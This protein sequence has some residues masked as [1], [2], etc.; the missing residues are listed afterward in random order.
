M[1]YLTRLQTTKIEMKKG[2]NFESA[3]KNLKPPLFWKDKD[4]FKKHCVNWP[5]ESIEKSLNK[6]SETEILCKLNSKLAILNCEK[7]I[8]FIAKHGRQYFQN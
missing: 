6:L 7:S 1:N 5:L 3:I 2:N 4:N 8:L